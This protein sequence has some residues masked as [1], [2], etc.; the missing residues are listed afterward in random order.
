[1]EATVQVHAR[2]SLTMSFADG[3]R[4]LPCSTLCPL[5][6]YSIPQFELDSFTKWRQLV[7]VV[8]LLLLQA[9]IL[10]GDYSK[11]P[12]EAIMGAH[13]RDQSLSIFFWCL[14]ANRFYVICLRPSE[15]LSSS[16]SLP[17]D[18]RL[19]TAGLPQL[20]ISCCH[21]PVN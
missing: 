14:I 15:R 12:H 7:T 2:V 11:L 20:A 8:S 1:M 5:S 16:I 21:S 6:F 13:Q 17:L 18:W 10:T 4:L 9:L 3:T 19:F